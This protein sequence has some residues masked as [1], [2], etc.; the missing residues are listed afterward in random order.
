MGCT[1]KTVLAPPTE[2]ISQLLDG[3][4]NEALAEAN[5]AVIDWYHRYRWRMHGEQLSAKV[6]LVDPVSDESQ[7]SSVPN[8]AAVPA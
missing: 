8:E 2:A 4:G 3:Y 1:D 5:Q 6:G 7:E